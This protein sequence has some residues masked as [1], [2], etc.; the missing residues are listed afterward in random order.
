MPTTK[1]AGGGLSPNAELDVAAPAAWRRPVK[2][3][4]PLPP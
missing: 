1:L 4:I 2:D 3:E